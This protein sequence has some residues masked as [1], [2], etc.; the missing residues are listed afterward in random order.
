MEI[1]AGK[2]YTGDKFSEGGLIRI[3]GGKI[4]S[5][6]GGSGASLVTPGFIDSHLHLLGLGL[7]LQ[8]LSLQDCPGMAE[9][10]KALAD[11]AVT[12]PDQ[13]LLGRGWDQNKL[14]FTP[15]RRLLDELCPQR[16]VILA[17]ACHHVVAANSLALKLAGITEDTVVEGGVLKKDDEGKL[18]GVLEENA[19][20][21]VYAPVP[22]ASRATLYSALVKAIQYVHCRGITGVHTD[23]RGQIGKYE[24]LWELYEQ[25]TASYPLR[26]QLHYSASTPQELEDFIRL[27][28]EI[29]DTEFIHKGAVKI[30]IDGSLG[31]RTAALL[32]DYQD[33]PGNSGVLVHPDDTVRELVGLAERAKVQLAVHVIGDGG[34]EQFLAAL[35]R[36]RGGY[37]AGIPHRLV[38][39]QVTNRSQIDRAKALGLAIEI[40]PVFLRTDMHWVES[41]L[42]QERL[43]ESYCWRTLAEAGLFLNGG[44]D[45]P[46]ED[47]NPWLGIDAAVTRRDGA[48]RFASSWRRDES[49]SLE[50]AL[51]L[52]TSAPARLAGWKSSGRIAP[53]CWADLAIYAEFSPDN[54]AKNRPDTVLV[55]G[56][57]VYQR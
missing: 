56:E 52:F 49:L 31:A 32:A 12:C 25:V 37:K 4:S 28:P 48:G 43:Q 15:D 44:S 55:Q 45:S 36:E 5:I 10:K 35:S 29:A 16:P 50:Q 18:T 41:R 11:Y 3:R 9:F 13:W 7:S 39:F 24:D 20:S 1:G 57:T 30:F 33:D 21:L 46:V 2:L 42:G 54:L 27:A 8:R 23:D 40:Q 51:A 22:A 19:T 53:G 17:R 34:V 47:A 6:E 14:G 26:V 38:H